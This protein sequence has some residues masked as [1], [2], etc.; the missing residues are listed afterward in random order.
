[1]ES[2]QV[3]TIWDAK[4][5][6]K[7]FTGAEGRY[8]QK[9]DRN[10]GVFIDDDTAKQLESDGWNVKYTKPNEEGYQRPYLKVKLNFKGRPRLYLV[11]DG[12]KTI[13]TEETAGELDDL[14]FEKVDLK[15]RHAYLKNYDCWTQYIDKG[16][17]TVLEDD[18]D[19]AYATPRDEFDE[20]MDDI[21]F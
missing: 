2:N 7:N 17:F 9:G 5:Y 14:V 15:I 21:P 12:R 4:L 6:F 18:L 11:A 10:F 20:A 16:Y 8:N 13:L 19:R 3:I 1:M